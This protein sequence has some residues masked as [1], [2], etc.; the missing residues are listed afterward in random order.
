M[1]LDIHYRNCEFKCWH[2]FYR[3]FLSDI[4]QVQMFKGMCEAAVF[5]HVG[6]GKILPMPL[7]H[8]DIYGSKQAGNRLR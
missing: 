6:T 2:S 3:Y 7:H 8:C 4:L 5:G 1:L